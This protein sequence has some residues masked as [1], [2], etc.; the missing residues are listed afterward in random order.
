MWEVLLHAWRIEPF[1]HLCAIMLGLNIG[2]PLILSVFSVT[3]NPRAPIKPWIVPLFGV[4]LLCALP[5]I[6]E[7]VWH[8]LW[9][10]AL[11]TVISVCAAL[12]FPYLVA[13]LLSFLPVACAGLALDYWLDGRHH[14]EP[15]PHK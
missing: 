12:G 14:R 9:G 4:V 8:R 7:T 6:V 5:M 10:K 1:L 13:F 15:S 3:I 2:I 11:T